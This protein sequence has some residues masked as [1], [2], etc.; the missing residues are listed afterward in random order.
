VEPATITR[1]IAR[2]PTSNVH[3]T[4]NYGRIAFVLALHNQSYLTVEGWDDS[5]DPFSRERKWKNKGVV[6][7]FQAPRGTILT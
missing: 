7:F 5:V 2:F 1:D 3:I 4:T 6:G